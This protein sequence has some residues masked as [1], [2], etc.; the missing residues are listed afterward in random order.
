MEKKKICWARVFKNI[1]YTIFPIILV[2]LLLLVFC[3]T[4]PLEKDAIKAKLDYYDTNTFAEHYAMEIFGSLSIVG[5]LKDNEQLDVYNSYYIR[6]EEI[7]GDDTIKELNYYSQCNR[8]NVNW[9]II[10]NDTKIAYTN[11][12][13]SI[14]TSN[15]K[16]ITTKIMKNKQNWKYENGKI[17]TTVSKLS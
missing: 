5:A 1:S 10:D 7:V 17:K 14:D 11:F 13:Y 16:D 3:L 12:E 15:L 9:L 2:A 4:Y 8:T 6:T